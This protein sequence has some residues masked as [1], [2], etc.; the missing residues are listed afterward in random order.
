[1]P[2]DNG[3]FRVYNRIKPTGGMTMFYSCFNAMN[4]ESGNDMS[5]HIIGLTLSYA[6]L[7]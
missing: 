7:G 6:F 4:N 1:M 5:V 3:M 2:I